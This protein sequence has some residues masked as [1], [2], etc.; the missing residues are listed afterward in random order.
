MKIHFELESDLCY[1]FSDLKS[2]SHLDVSSHL[3]FCSPISQKNPF[4]LQGRVHYTPLVTYHWQATKVCSRL[5][6]SLVFYLCGTQNNTLARL[7][8]TD[9]RFLVRH[10]HIL[11]ITPSLF[12]RA[13]LSSSA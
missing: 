13:I 4:K 7:E 11:F 1:S 5:S 8:G 10:L 12:L 2:P 3:R 6:D 9:A